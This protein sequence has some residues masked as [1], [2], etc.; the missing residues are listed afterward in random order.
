MQP[1]Q[2]HGVSSMTR[3]S[4]IHLLRPGP[5]RSTLGPPSRDR[6]R[7]RRVKRHPPSHVGTTSKLGAASASRSGDSRK[8]TDHRAVPAQPGRGN[9]RCC[10]PNG[11]VSAAAAI[12]QVQRIRR[13]LS[14]P[15]GNGLVWALPSLGLR[16]RLATRPRAA[17][18]PAICPPAVNALLSLTPCVCAAFLTRP[19][20]A[21][22]QAAKRP[23]QVRTAA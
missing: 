8:T 12:H 9:G 17:W 22:Y 2:R 20:D 3:S 11:V 18:T 13:Q 7:R 1:V 19:S 23:R 21:W 6:S 15:G 10:S 16:A 5:A 14:C 4:M